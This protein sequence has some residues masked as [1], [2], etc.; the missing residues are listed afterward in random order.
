ME[1]EERLASLAAK[2]RQQKAAIQTEEAT[3]T[4]FV[5]PFIQSVLGYDV[6][7]PLEVVPEFTADVG[8]KK[9][10]KVDYAIL[11]DGE[12]QILIESK[13]I[14]EPLNIN[15]ASQLFRY[16][17][18][19]SARISILTNGRVYKFFT[20]LDA[21]NKMDEKPFLEL[22]LLDI[23]DH[24]IPELQKLTKSA[25]DVDSIISAAGE[26]KYVGQIKR[27]LAAQ[28]SNPDDDFVRLFASRV[29]D[30][31]LTQKVREQFAQLT[32]KATSQF[33]SDQ[34]NDRL[35][36]AIS[37]GSQT[38]IA[39][40]PV[41]ATGEASPTA[42][43]EVEKDKVV[44]TAEEIEGYNIVKAIVRT[45][46]DAKRIAARDTQSYFGV[47]LD[48]NNRKPIARLHFNRAQKYIGIFDA[49]KNETRQPIETLDDIFT[50]AEALK[51]TVRSYEDS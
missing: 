29:Y 25:F 12:V 47:L 21:P 48:D 1:F 2:I 14:G 50:H 19:T 4:A 18:V 36:S 11:K 35:K 3:K 28:F 46:V 8:T 20:D 13:K 31:I 44:T 9:G 27:A 38:V 51:A 23:D 34:V 41:Q 6:F 7:N 40:Q 30:G 17:H 32:R 45:E 5:M 37:G 49:D 42:V 16:F 15:H 26:L 10:E 33:L 43:E 22:D 39:A 24:A